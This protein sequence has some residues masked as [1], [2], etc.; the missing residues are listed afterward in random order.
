MSQPARAAFV[1]TPSAMPDLASAPPPA[2]AQQPQPPRWIW[3]AM[4]AGSRRDQMTQM[5]A[6]VDWLRTRHQEP[7]F[8]LQEKIPIC[9]YMH[10]GPLEVLTALYAEW[11][12]IYSSDSELPLLSFYDAVTRHA[13]NLGY[14]GQCLRRTHDD[15]RDVEP[16]Q[17][18]ATWLKT[19]IWATAPALTIDFL[20]ERTPPMPTASP[21]QQPHGRSVFSE[22]DITTLVEGGLAQRLGR[23]PAVRMDGTWWIGA[24]DTYV[25]VPDAALAADLDRRLA[26]YTAGQ[27]AI[28]RQR[29]SALP[30]AAAPNDIPG[31][32][33]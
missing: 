12:R 23:T 1:P 28:A 6:W 4:P 11:I 7:P 9:W 15:G 16:F 21:V 13:P 32:T 10:P 17:D 31:Q 30:G 18:F 3:E 22:A 8:A 19:S 29:D 14:P 25:A 5:A 27:A 2:T 33:Q 24:G 26:K 20:P